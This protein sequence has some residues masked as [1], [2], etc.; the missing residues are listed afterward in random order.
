[1][2]AELTGLPRLAGFAGWVVCEQAESA[3]VMKAATERN[4]DPR[5]AIPI[6]VSNSFS[7]GLSPAA[8]T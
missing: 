6:F 8:A 7:E 2:P 4:R 5:S 3:T 1:M